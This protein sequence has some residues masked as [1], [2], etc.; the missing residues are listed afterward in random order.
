M[1]NVLIKNPLGDRRH[2]FPE[3]GVSRREAEAWIQQYGPAPKGWQYQVVN[4]HRKPKRILTHTK[5]VGFSRE[6]TVVGT[7]T[8]EVVQKGERYTLK[9][10]KRDLRYKGASYI[11]KEKAYVNVLPEVQGV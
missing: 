2:E 5:L 9:Q 7:I 3:P 10:A 1:F 8:V 4:L 6:N 11:I